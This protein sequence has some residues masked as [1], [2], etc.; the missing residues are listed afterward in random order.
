M[1]S[2]SHS[3][4]N[5]AIPWQWFCK[6]TATITNKIVVQLNNYFENTQI[7][8]INF[9]RNLVLLTSL[10][11]IDILLFIANKNKHWVINKQNVRL[12]HIELEFVLALNRLNKIHAN[13]NAVIAIV[14]AI[15][16]AISS[17][18]VNSAT[19]WGKKIIFRIQL[20]NDYFS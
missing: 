5:N 9:H 16:D 3:A 17:I 6:R 20:M 19:Y 7:F 15:H 8:K 10:D 18:N 14:K 4:I 1:T 2:T 13:A 12:I 11:T